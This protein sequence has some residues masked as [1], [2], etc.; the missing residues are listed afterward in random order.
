VVIA[1]LVDK[2][3]ST[4]VAVDL[5]AKAAAKLV[6]AAAVL[7]RQSRSARLAAE[8]SLLR[9]SLGDISSPIIHTYNNT[10]KV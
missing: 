3:A 6:S 1:D 8:I 10:S 7:T 4:S 2:S 5:A 9:N